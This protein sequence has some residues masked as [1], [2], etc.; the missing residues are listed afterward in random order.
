MPVLVSG[1]TTIAGWIALMNTNVPA[2]LEIGA[3]AR[4]GVASLTLLTAD[5]VPLPRSRWCRCAAA[6]AGAHGPADWLA[7]RIDTL[8]AWI[9]E[10]HAAPHRRRSSWASLSP[11]RS[12]PR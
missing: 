8:L 9:A 6:G 4:L 1:L 11:R 3:F 10:L 5:G 2:V 7:G 12:P